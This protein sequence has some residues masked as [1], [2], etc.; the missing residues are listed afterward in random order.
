MVSLE[1]PDIRQGEQ[2]H[3]PSLKG[4][5]FNMFLTCDLTKYACHYM[6][7]N[8]IFLTKSAEQWNLRVAHE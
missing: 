7:I 2:H 1:D 4:C 3:V 8:C 6:I 5:Q